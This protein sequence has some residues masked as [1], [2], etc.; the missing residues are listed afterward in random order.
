MKCY[1]LVAWHQCSL[2]LCRL[3][4][5]LPSIFAAWIPIDFLGARRIPIFLPVKKNRFFWP[6]KSIF[7]CR[8][9][10]GKKTWNTTIFPGRKSSVPFLPRAFCGSTCTATAPDRAKTLVSVGMH[11]Y[12][13]G[14]VKCGKWGIEWDVIQWLMIWDLCMIFIKMGDSMRIWWY[15][16]HL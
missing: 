2:A 15:K 16:L 7:V 6:V 12:P 1:P 13:D 3:K 11:H 8:K 4:L 14:E 5:W 9:K 10:H